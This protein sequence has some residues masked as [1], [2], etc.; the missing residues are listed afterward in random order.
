METDY[1]FMANFLINKL[2]ITRCVISGLTLEEYF[3]RRKYN[4]EIE[5]ALCRMILL[6]RISKL[7]NVGGLLSTNSD[8]CYER[9]VHLIASLAEQSW[10]LT[11][12]TIY[13][14]LST[15]HT[16]IF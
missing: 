10:G 3:D 2:L 15:I 5:L 11:L 16:T 1:K 12:P 9:V 14:I 4:R 6:E 13:M 8:Q 7:S